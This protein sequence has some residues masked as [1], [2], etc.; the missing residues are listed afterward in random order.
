MTAIYL[1]TFCLGVSGFLAWRDIT[2]INKEADFE[3]WQAQAS[4]SDLKESIQTLK[5]YFK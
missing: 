5:I 1:L 2:R 4:I 3:M